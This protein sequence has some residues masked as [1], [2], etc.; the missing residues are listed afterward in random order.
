MSYVAPPNAQRLAVSVGRGLVRLP[1]Q[2]R[3]PWSAGDAVNGDLGEPRGWSTATL[4]FSPT[5]VPS[6]RIVH[7][8]AMRSMGWAV[9]LVLVSAGL[10]QLA[11]RPAVIVAILTFGV[12]WSLLLP[13]AYVPLTS[14]IIL[15]CL[16][17][18]AARMMQLALP[19]TAAGG[20]SHL[21]HHTRGKKLQQGA[22]TAL[23]AL[24]VVNLITTLAS[25]QGG[26]C[27][28]E[29]CGR[30]RQRGRGT[31]LLQRRRL[32]PSH[33]RPPRNRAAETQEPPI[34]SVFIP[35]DAEQN[36]AGGKYYVPAD[37]YNR[38]FRMA[39]G[40]RRGPKPWLITRARYQGN[41]VR[42]PGTKR[43]GLSELKAT[44]DVVVNQAACTFAYLF[45]ARRFEG[46]CE[47][48]ARR[49]VDGDELERRRR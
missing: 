26:G 31:S 18:M 47:R 2:S 36:L 29:Q 23:V 12:V 41:L 1:E 16:V 24:A 30:Q 20:H 25:A 42:D 6:V 5:G 48:R 46:D 44:L 27:S 34:A 7:I 17:L 14:S 35:I 8:A 21:S 43:L 19:R 4:Q 15:A 49:P 13:A 39:D 40:V 9:F 37:L 10:W 28:P 3:S 32:I 45:R 11:R 38:L 22:L 33:P